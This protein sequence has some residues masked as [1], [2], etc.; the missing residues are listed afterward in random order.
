MITSFN[1]LSGSLMM[2]FGVAAIFFFR[3][4]SKTRDRLFAAFGIAFTILAFERIV[5][6]AGS[7]YNTAEDHP[8]IYFMRLVAFLTILYGINA[9]NR[10]A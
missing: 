10:Q 7:S 9:K 3:F 5:L 4:W 8:Q 1:F 2:G 6:F